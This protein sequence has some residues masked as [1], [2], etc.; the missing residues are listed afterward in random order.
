MEDE[1]Y[2]GEA[3][4]GSSCDRDGKHA[5]EA[6]TTAQREAGGAEEPRR[7]DDEE[8]IAND[9]HCTSRQHLSQ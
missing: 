9:V 5:D 4:D 3:D 6:D 1:V 8:R 7:G 2:V